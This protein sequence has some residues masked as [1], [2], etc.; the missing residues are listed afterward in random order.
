[1]KN[2][3]TNMTT[4]E[5]I[6]LMRHGLESGVFPKVLYKY[7]RMDGVRAVLAFYA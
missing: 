5:K 2:M 1:M 7:M 6:D 3:K 4:R